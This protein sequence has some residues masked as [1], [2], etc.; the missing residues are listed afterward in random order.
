[1]LYPAAGH[2][3]QIMVDEILEEL[4]DAIQ[5]A[6][7]ALKQNLGKLRT[8]R[9]HA[10]MLDSIKVDYYG[11]L[12]PISQMATV[13]VPEARLLTVKAWD[14]A[15]TAQHERNEPNATKRTQRNERNNTDAAKQ[16]QRNER[17]D[18]NATIRT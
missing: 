3:G 13:N 8:G 15:H 18:T 12:T 11:A 10:G 17:S 7:A 6:Q 5:K 1:M 16:P 4:R 9:A 2:R 14:K